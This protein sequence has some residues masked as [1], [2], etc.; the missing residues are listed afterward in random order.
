MLLSHI[1]VEGNITWKEIFFVSTPQQFKKMAERIVP[2]LIAKKD[3]PCVIIPPLPRYPFSPCCAAKNHRPNLSDPDFPTK[4]LSDLIVLCNV[5]IKVVSDCGTRNTR[6]VDSCPVTKCRSTD[7]LAVRLTNLKV[8][9]SDDGV[10][11]T[12]AG[13][14]NM[15]SICI[16]TLRSVLA[17][18]KNSASTATKKLKFYWLGFKSHRGASKMGAATAYAARLKTQLLAGPPSQAGTGPSK[19]LSGVRGGHGGRGYGHHFYHPYRR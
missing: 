18:A 9:A 17:R 13:L 6:V 12:K 14:L 19:K 7:N 16:S 10:H 8:V 1:R 3:A 11:Y 15:A 4:I 5:L 2:I